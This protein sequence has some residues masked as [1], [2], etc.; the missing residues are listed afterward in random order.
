MISDP[1]IFCAPEY[2]TKLMQA[3]PGGAVRAYSASLDVSR[4]QIAALDGQNVRLA[5]ILFM[6]IQTPQSNQPVK[7][8][9]NLSSQNP[10]VGPV[11]LSKGPR[12]PDMSSVYES[13]EGTIAVLGE[14]EDLNN[15]MEPWTRVTGGIWEAIAL[16]QRGYKIQAWVIADLDKWINET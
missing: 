7:D 8:H 13:K 11:D 10:L 15:F 6:G 4:D 5:I 16:K 14:D 3:F 2:Q 12:F 9:I 1:I